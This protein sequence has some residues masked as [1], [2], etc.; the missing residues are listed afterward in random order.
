[1]TIGGTDFEG[2]S[3]VKFG[4]APAPSFQVNSDGQITAIVPAAAAGAVNVAVTTPAGTATSS[5]QFTYMPIATCIV[6]KLRGKKLKAARKA[7]AKVD[8]KLG[9]VKKLK[10]A[11][12]KTGKVTKQ[13]PKPGKVLA[14]G[15]KVN[16]KLGE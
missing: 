6:P 9:K 8:C 15:A 11:T 10:G 5:Q 1:V 3:A 12:S 4:S 7:L 13:H 16:V 2:A 14:P